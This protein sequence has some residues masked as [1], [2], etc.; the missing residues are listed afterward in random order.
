MSPIDE[1]TSGKSAAL[2]ALSDSKRLSRQTDS[3]I[4]TAR[5]TLD[6]VRQSREENHFANKF[7]RIIRGAA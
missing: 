2:K 4:A 6:Q 3:M 1:N 7:R 5:E